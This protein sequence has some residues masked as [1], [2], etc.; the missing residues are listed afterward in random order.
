LFLR[1]FEVWHHQGTPLLGFMATNIAGAVAT[2]AIFAR[3]IRNWDIP[4]ILLAVLAAAV[5]GVIWAQ[6]SDNDGSGF[7]TTLKWIALVDFLLLNLAL[8]L[9]VLQN[10]LLPVLDRRDARKA[11]ATEAEA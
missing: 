2:L 11:A 5:A 1:S 3:F 6:Q 9:Q 7:A 10:G 8:G 4:L